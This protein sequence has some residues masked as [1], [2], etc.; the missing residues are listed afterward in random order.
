MVDQRSALSLIQ[1]DG[2]GA[3]ESMR[4]WRSQGREI[5]HVP[6]VTPDVQ[7]LMTAETDAR[8]YGT[9]GPDPPRARLVA[10]RLLRSERVRARA[11]KSRADRRRYAD[12]QGGDQWRP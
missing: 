1:D 5:C 4:R 2:T 7:E 11:E 3:L 12:S 8:E 6:L 10:M 9:L